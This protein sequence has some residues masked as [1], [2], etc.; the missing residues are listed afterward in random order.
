MTTVNKAAAF[1]ALDV[2]A[3]RR[4]GL[5]S[6]MQKA[7]YTLET[8]RPVV[9]EWACS[10]TGCAFTT[11]ENTGRVAL[12]SSHKKYEA[13][14]TVVRDVMLMLQ[15]TTRHASQGKAD[16]DPVQDAIKALAKLTPAQLR[17]VLAA[18]A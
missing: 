15:G 17:K 10:K 16:R 18:I 2:F 11:N 3:D 12:V 6:E 7:G 4:A 1:K 14:K 13:T 5:I 9:I 8:A